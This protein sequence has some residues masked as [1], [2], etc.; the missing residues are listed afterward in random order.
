MILKRSLEARS[1][2]TQGG[3]VFEDSS[4]RLLKKS[5]VH[6]LGTFFEILSFGWEKW[7]SLR[8]SSFHFVANRGPSWLL[9]PVGNEKKR[10][11]LDGLGFTSP[12][13]GSLPICQDSMARPN[14]SH[15]NRLPN[16]LC[17]RCRTRLFTSANPANRR[18]WESFFGHRSNTRDA[19]FIVDD[20]WWLTTKPKSSKI[21]L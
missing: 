16:F 3:L 5:L 21:S 10:F 6:N 17:S 7:F 13:F 18:E 2:Q 4:L 14:S 19:Y 8:D 20:F 1:W 9:M 12:F 15:V 11:S